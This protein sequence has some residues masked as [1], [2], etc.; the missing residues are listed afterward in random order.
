AQLAGL[1]VPEPRPAAAVPLLCDLLPAVGV[2]AL[3]PD[4]RALHAAVQR[5][6]AH[7]RADARRPRAVPARERGLSRR[8]RRDRPDDRPA[9][10]RQA[11]PQVATLSGTQPRLS[12]CFRRIAGTDETKG[13]A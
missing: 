11:P 2:P 3:A 1:R 10:H 5:D 12:A 9:A 7:P 13:D 8:L 4:R 6:L